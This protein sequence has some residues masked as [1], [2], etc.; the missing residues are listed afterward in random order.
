[1]FDIAS[2]ELL[3]VA[4]VALVAVGPKELP[5]LVRGISSAMRTVRSMAAEFRAG[6]DTL[7]REVEQSI[8]PDGDMR[9]DLD[10]LRR[11]EGITSDMTPEAITDHIMANRAREEEAA[12]A[13]QEILAA[14]RD[15]S[16]AEADLVSGTPAADAEAKT[17]VE[18]GKD[19]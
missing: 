6:F 5:A 10:A 9:S 11:A 2:S 15:E 13:K 16:A 4:V 12:K 1:M 19:V 3:I 7:A 17:T 18:D 14:A 8:D